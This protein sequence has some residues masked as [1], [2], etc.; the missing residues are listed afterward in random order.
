M[1]L[2]ENGFHLESRHVRVKPFLKTYS[3]LA[4]T[5][6]GG[7]RDSFTVGG[8]GNESLAHLLMGKKQQEDYKAHILTPPEP[9]PESPGV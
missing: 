6:R 4:G 2:N 7:C 8:P 9:G 5:S 3:G 1:V